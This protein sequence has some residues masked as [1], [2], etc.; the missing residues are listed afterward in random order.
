[1]TNSA[2]TTSG[3]GSVGALATA[4][5]SISLNGNTIA[6]SGAGADGAAVAGP[7]ATLTFPGNNTITTTGAQANGV[8]AFD[9]GQLA[10]DAGQAAI[11]VQGS[12]SAVYAA[13]GT[14]AASGTA[15]N[16]SVAPGFTIQNG[17]SFPNTIGALAQSGGMVNF[18]SGSGVTMTG[19]DVIGAQS[20][21]TGS[22]VNADT[23]GFTVNGDDARAVQADNGGTINLNG[24]TVTATGTNAYGVLSTQGGNA[25]LNGVNIS[26]TGDGAYGAVVEGPTSTLTLS[27]T[28]MVATSGSAAHGIVA[29]NGGQL[30]VGSPLQA[31]V[32]GTGSAVVA[33]I[34]TDAT[35]GAASA[36]QVNGA[37]IQNSGTFDNTIGALAQSG[38][39]LNFASG[40]GVTMTGNGVIGAQSTGAG[41][42]V[43]ADTASFTVN[44]DHARGVQ[45]DS[46]G[47]VTLNGGTVT[48]AGTDAYGVLSTQGGIAALNGVNISTTGDG[49][50]GAV[51]DGVNSSL[52]VA[53]SNT[54]S[55]NGAA[56]H[57][58]VA[59][60][61]GQLT[62]NDASTVNGSVQS[63]GSAVVAAIGTDAMSGA[64]STIQVNGAA[65]QTGGS[66][67][68][69]IG[70]LAQSGGVVNFASGSGVTMMGGGVI[71][72]Q[73]TGA[74]SQVDADTAS[75]AVN[76][77]TARGVQA[78]NGGT[79]TLNGGTVS[80]TGTNAY[81]VL[82]TQ[83]GIAALN[84]VN[85]STT[86]DGAY[87]AV[88]EGPTSSLTLS[89]TNMVATSGSAAHG[90]VALDGGQ[91]S[92]SSPLQAMMS[93]A[94]SAVLAAIGKDA[95]SGTA[96]TIQ[97]NGAT[98][99]NGGSFDNTIGV[100][101]KDGGVVNYSGG[102][103]TISGNNSLGLYATGNG[104]LISTVQG[105]TVNTTGANG[106]ATAVSNGAT[107]NIS[108]SKVMATGANPSALLLSGS[109]GTATFTN[110]TLS[111]ALSDTL[112]AYG[113]S[114][115]INLF[116]GTTTAAGTGNLLHAMAD[117]S[118]N[119]SNAVLNL[120]N[121]QLA[122]D[123]L[124]E[125]DGSNAD[126]HLVDSVLTGKMTNAGAVT[127]DPSTWVVTGSS[128]V[129]TLA[130]NNSVIAFQPPGS[131]NA[132]KSLLVHGNYTS[133][134]GTII[135]V[136][137]Q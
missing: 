64:A 133:A 44:G 136:C 66:F 54:V 132:Y 56:A 10:V 94:G 121:V 5:G 110:S 68:D 43:N 98:I 84:G 14:D 12:G 78:D 6:T 39:V 111:S 76:G 63:T 31:M 99:Q 130:L 88:V 83:G 40:S 89:G 48:T 33:A 119:A 73:A 20:S 26:T 129:R 116:D 137:G 101:A 127:L 91:L 23:T 24:G 123:I 95:A 8:A 100:L 122:G 85:I 46:G 17:G 19:G 81:G 87:G 59:L 37:T 105:T 107:L 49:A 55:T 25:A 90:V 57:G 15:S 109:N 72:T 62:I 16:I 124:V 2:I 69:T 30:S 22:Q 18:A 61:G 21:G 77:D 113:G 92:V 103:V 9:G 134:N 3:D 82:S 47:A 86:G 79:V 1:V 34:G 131:Q 70:A 114:G 13:V 96:S 65:I 108:G 52:S 117:A 135:N 67:D 35:S 32:S 74:G 75:F 42:Q 45:A 97:V 118:G 102:S 7:A 125:A 38:G 28:T 106:H 29:L 80:A 51:V 36:I 27:G 4:N 126:V 120:R 60:N 115:T 58:L 50:Y 11:T 112:L 104:A 71:G 93:G 53:G 128:D 41:S